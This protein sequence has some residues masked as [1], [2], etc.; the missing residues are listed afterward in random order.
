MGDDGDGWPH[1][2]CVFSEKT[3]ARFE[4]S[5]A[6]S[7]CIVASK[8]TRYTDA[9]KHP[10]LLQAQPRNRKTRRRIND[11]ARVQ[12]ASVLVSLLYGGPKYRRRAKTCELDSND[13]KVPRL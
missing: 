1:A 5:E 7:L 6:V 2:T 8:K 13:G 3:F 4:K 9:F 11:K 10:S 12:K